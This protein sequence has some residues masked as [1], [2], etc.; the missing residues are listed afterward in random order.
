M[1]AIGIHEELESSV[2][3]YCRRFP[4]VFARARGH[5]LWTEEGREYLDL[6][7][8]AGALNYG[9][10]HPALIRALTDYLGSDGVVHG[11]DLHT[12]AKAEF[13]STVRRVLFVPRNLDYRV[14]FTGP[15]GTNAVEAALKV[16]RRVT[17]RAS[18]I[19]FTNG[20]HGLS[21]GALPLTG[22]AFKR[23]A[24]GVPLT[25][26][27]RMPYDGYLGPDLDTADY[28]DHVL[29]DPGSGIDPPAAVVLETVQAEGG[30]NVAGPDWLQ[31]IAATARRHGALLVVDDIQAGCGRTGTF[32][33][34]EAA[35][36]VP[37]LVCLSKSISGL[38]LPLALT[39]VRPELDCLGPG[40]HSGTFRGH[41]LAFVTG[42]AALR[43]WENPGFA[44][45][46]TATATTLDRRLTAL[47][48]RH[49]GLGTHPRG[50]GLLRG[51]GFTDP[52]VAERVSA[53]AFRLGLLVETSG[54]V[55]QVLK[56]LPPITLDPPELAEALDVLDHALS[57]V[58]SSGRKPP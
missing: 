25:H 58:A 36:I 50:R 27:D 19:S 23:A 56:V 17:G 44:D 16:A 18:V 20:F 26:V 10:N 38:G 42:T 53:T 40:E 15:T 12:A 45:R 28:L 6:L 49:A 1:T 5:R 21:L 11:L 47:S 24:A 51:L 22:T 9:H 46:L 34:F 32:F 29:T 13:L 54:A 39:L 41:N 37:D 7:A 57:E 4:V 35:G 48:A 14:M 3:T 43:L 30:L 55:S 31:R 2:R 52:T 33:S 8:G